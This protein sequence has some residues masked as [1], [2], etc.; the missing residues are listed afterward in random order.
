MLLP[1]DKIVAEQRLGPGISAPPLEEPRVVLA[2]EDN[3]SDKVVFINANT[4]RYTPANRDYVVGVI[5]Q[6][7]ADVYRVRLQEYS[8]PVRLSHLAFQG[9]TKKNKPNLNVGDVVY[10]RITHCDKDTEVE[11][12]CVDSSS[13]KAMGFG[14]LKEGNIISVGLGYARK[15]LFEGHPV[16]DAIGAKYQYELAIGMNGRIW[17]KANDAKTTLAIC[18]WIKTAESQGAQTVKLVK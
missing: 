17:V 5:S 13:G 2:G 4:K 16:L 11:M 18:N 14:Q 9:A 15:L 8:K 7:L 1:G 10:G 3:W 12:E 6:R